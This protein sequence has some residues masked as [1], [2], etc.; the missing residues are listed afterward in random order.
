MYRWHATTSI[1]DEQWIGAAFK[2]FFGDKQ[3]E[4]V[5]YAHL[6]GY[7]AS[8]CYC[9]RL[10]RGTSLWLRRKPKK[11][12]RIAS[13]GHSESE[14]YFLFFN[15]D[16]IAYWE[17]QSLKRQEDG[18]FS[19]ADLAR[20]LQDATSHPASAFKARGTPAIMRLNEI[21]GMEQSRRWGVCSLNDFRKVCIQLLLPFSSI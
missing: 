6:L 18:S 3:P 20:V 9:V 8:Q 11:W 16:H 15:E 12:N 4:E 17:S 2:Q 14:F 19:D 10:P 21:M 5:S 7:A 1:E 13:T